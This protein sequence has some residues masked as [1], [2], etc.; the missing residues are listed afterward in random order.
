LDQYCLVLIYKKN[1][2]C[3]D[4]FHEMMEKDVFLMKTIRA[5]APGLFF[6][7]K[8]DITGTGKTC[9]ET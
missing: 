5:A 6:R 3:R 2:D 9:Q 4:F 1:E 8:R 7:S